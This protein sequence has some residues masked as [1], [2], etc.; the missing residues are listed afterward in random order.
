M[1]RAAGVGGGARAEGGQGAAALRRCEASPARRSSASGGGWRRPASSGHSCCG[2][3]RRKGFT[4]TV[5]RGIIKYIMNGEMHLSYWRETPRERDCSLKLSVPAHIKPVGVRVRLRAA[6]GAAVWRCVVD[7]VDV[8]AVACRPRCASPRTEMPLTMD[9]CSSSS[10]WWIV[11][12]LSSPPAPAEGGPWPC[13]R[14]IAPEIGPDAF[15]PA[16]PRSVGA[17]AVPAGPGPPALAAAPSGWWL[18][19]RG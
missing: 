12:S 2:R 15:P 5:Y 6:A 18:E 10:C 1:G 17:E 14:A 19:G 13:G 3:D 8:L 16:R 9:C 4:D 11:E 7:A